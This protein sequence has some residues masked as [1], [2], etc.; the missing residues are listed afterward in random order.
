MMIMS[1]V[2]RGRYLAQICFGHEESP[3]RKVKAIQQ[4]SAGKACAGLK[5]LI[6]LV[7]I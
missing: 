6:S 5:A 3:D 7:S 2:I 4:Q 1:Q